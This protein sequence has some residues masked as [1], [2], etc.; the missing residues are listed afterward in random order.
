MN[1]GASLGAD[2]A[3]ADI[4]SG[5]GSFAAPTPMSPPRLSL[6]PMDSCREVWQALAH[7]C[8]Q[9]SIYHELEWQRVLHSAYGST[10]GLSRVA[11][12]RVLGAHPHLGDASR[13]GRGGGARPGGGRPRRD[14]VFHAWPGG[15]RLPA[16]A[17][18]RGPRPGRGYA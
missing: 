1:P 12:L 2:R 16:A 5:Y 15:G 18:R 4:A 11:A 13:A 7:R 6:L 8:P 14:R 9:S 17:P 10:P 3:V